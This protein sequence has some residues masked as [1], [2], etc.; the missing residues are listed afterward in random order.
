MDA[1]GGQVRKF[2]EKMGVTY[3]ILLGTQAVA[4]RYL[5]TG[6][7]ITFYIDRNGRITDQTPGLTPRSVIENEIKLALVNGA[8][9]AK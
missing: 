3:P 4:D 6:L 5:V 2:A 8:A 1:S 7:P 9:P